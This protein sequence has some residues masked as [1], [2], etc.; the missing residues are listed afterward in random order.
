MLS[1]GAERPVP[2]TGRWGNW[3]ETVLGSSARGNQS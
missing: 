1:H 3:A 2:R